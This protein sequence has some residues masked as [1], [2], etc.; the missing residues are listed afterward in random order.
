MRK[1][2]HMHGH[3]ASAIRDRIEQM[4]LQGEIEAGARINELRLAAMLKV[5]RGPVREA[6]RGL[7]RAGLLVAIP[8]RGM[9]VRK[10]ELEEALHLYDVRA[11]LARLAAA[12]ATRRAAPKDVRRVQAHYQRM[13]AA[14]A[15]RDPA[16]FLRGNNAFHAELLTLSGNP[17]LIELDEAVRNELQLYLGK[18]VLASNQ[19]RKSQAEHKAVLAAL[20]AGNAEAAGAAFE[21]HVHAGKERMLDY[22]G[23]RTVRKAS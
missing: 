6:L 23:S 13:E 3:L 5:S 16:Q 11:A 7:E 14:A 19:M 21:A 17:R 4:V 20:Q 18:S 10:V 1:I 8:N 22:I 9:F 12:L 2:V 15:A